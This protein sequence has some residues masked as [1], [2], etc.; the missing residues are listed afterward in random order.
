MKV[1][2]TTEA[3]KKLGDYLDSFINKDEHVFVLG[4]RDSPEAILIKYPD[5]YKNSLSDITNINLYSSSF[6]FLKNEPNL[7]TIKDAISFYK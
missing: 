1:I 7:Y 4:R 6:D 3:R 2:N 5:A